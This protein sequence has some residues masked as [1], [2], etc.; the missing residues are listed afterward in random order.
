MVCSHVPRA[1][2]CAAPLR[3][4]DRRTG[5]PASQQIGRHLAPTVKARGDRPARGQLAH[6]QPPQ[7]RG[8]AEPAEALSKAE[9]SPQKNLLRGRFKRARL[10]EVEAFTAS[11]PFD[12]RLYRHDILGSIAHARMLAKVGLLTPS[13]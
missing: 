2:V 3:S 8:R 9:G 13:E 6:S 1:A 11:L 5:K 4:V 7:N 10:P 12:R